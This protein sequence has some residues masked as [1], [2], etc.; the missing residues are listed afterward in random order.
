MRTR[1][2]HGV[3]A[4]AAVSA[5]CFTAAACDGSDGKKPSDGKERAEEDGGKAAGASGTPLTAAQM[6]A[7]TL[8]AKDL[9]AGYKASKPDEA[10][11]EKYTTDKQDCAPIA[12]FLN[13]KVAGATTGG[14]VDFAGEGGDAMLTQRV[15]TFPGRGAEDHVKAVGAALEVCTSFAVAQGGEKLQI[16]VKKITGPKAGE[17]SHT[18]RMKTSIPSLSLN[19][20]SDLMVA[21]QG[22]GVTRVAFIPADASGHKA[23]GDLARRAGDKFAKGVQS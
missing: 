20:E 3:A 8:V 13:E 16:T 14:M 11:D 17:E 9:P 23:F 10:A 4:V 6:A 7:G 22:S 19:F 21:R 5:L 2:R 12:A 18:F 1:I 15:F